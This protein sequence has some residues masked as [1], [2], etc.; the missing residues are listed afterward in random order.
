MKKELFGKA[1]IK[2]LYISGSMGRS[3]TQ[4]EESASVLTGG[5]EIPTPS[6]RTVK[7]SWTRGDTSSRKLNE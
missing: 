3:V 6:V 7:A 2:M 4:V 5:G 1:A